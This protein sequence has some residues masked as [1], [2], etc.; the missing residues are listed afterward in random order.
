MFYVSRWYDPSLG[1]FVQADALIPE[2]TQGTQ[3][4]DRY[5]YV[6]NNLVRYNDPTGHMIDK[7]DGGC[8]NPDPDCDMPKSE[9]STT[10]TGKTSKTGDGDITETSQISN[11]P[12]CETAIQFEDCKI[13]EIE[14]SENELHAI[15]NI[16]YWGRV[17]EVAVGGIGGTA[18]LPEGFLIWAY[19]GWE[20]ND[21]DAVYDV[22]S[23]AYDRAVLSPDHKTVVTIWNSEKYGFFTDF[24][25]VDGNPSDPGITA[26]VA[27][28]INLI[29]SAYGALT[30]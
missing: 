29:I 14:F 3:A 4:W 10:A 8:S 18:T 21:L 15:V 7:G 13:A 1:R 17:G 9:T 30:D 23:D 27:R 26:P 28:L 5:A 25:H 2:S 19:T 11:L 22:F 16:L 24:I 20:Y 6:N 12:Q